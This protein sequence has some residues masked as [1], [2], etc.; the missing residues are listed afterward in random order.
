MAYSAEGPTRE[1]TSLTVDASAVGMR[2]AA[3]GASEEVSDGDRE[4]ERCRP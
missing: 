3:R 1:T 2:R 4:L